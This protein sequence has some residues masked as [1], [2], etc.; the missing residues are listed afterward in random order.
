[1]STFQSLTRPFSCE[2]SKNW[3][4][5]NDFV[6]KIG[7]GDDPANRLWNCSFKFT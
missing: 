4:L 6:S 7:L 2:V 5:L 1:M 3:L